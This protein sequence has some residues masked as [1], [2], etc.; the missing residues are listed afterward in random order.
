MAPSIALEE[1]GKTA[2][3]VVHEILKIEGVGKVV[4][5]IGRPEAGSHPHPVNFAE[6][7][8][9]PEPGAGTDTIAEEIR[10]RLKGFPGVQINIGQPIQHQFDE[11]L[12][13]VR[14]QLAIKIYG[15]ERETTS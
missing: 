13:G 12:S 4:T 14:A 1:A 10:I 5:R 2:E 6:V 3:Q 7:H 8:V 15:E 9:E 11:L